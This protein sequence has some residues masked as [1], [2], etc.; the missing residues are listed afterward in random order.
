MDL[1]VLACHRRYLRSRPPA[2]GAQSSLQGNFHIL[3]S[4]T[5]EVFFGISCS[6][7][8]FG[9]LFP[10]P[11]MCVL[12]SVRKI[13]R[14]F[15]LVQWCLGHVGVSLSLFSRWWRELLG[16]V[17]TIFTVWKGKQIR[18]QYKAQTFLHGEVEV[19]LHLNHTL[20]SHCSGGKTTGEPAI[21]VT[22]SSGQ[23]KWMADF[24]GLC[25]GKWSLPCPE[26]AL[27]SD[28]VL[29]G[30]AWGS[31]ALTMENQDFSHPEGTSQVMG[32]LVK[33]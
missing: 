24:D 7:L 6:M 8:R 14:L 21:V 1:K 5:T 25:E 9:Y 15:S 18:S 20:K 22:N 27:L 13:T 19:P 16:N 4:T 23:E 26:T 28:S 29:E 33:I 17:I 32:L 31:L 11:V 2:P 30:T 12:L 10:D 3:I